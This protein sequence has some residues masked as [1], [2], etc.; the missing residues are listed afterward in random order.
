MITT[1]TNYYLYYYLQFPQTQYGTKSYDTKWSE[2]QL[3]KKNKKLHLK[4]TK[5]KWKLFLKFIPYV[6]DY[7]IFF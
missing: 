3:N 4:K 5:Y 2:S 6:L 7:V 1:A